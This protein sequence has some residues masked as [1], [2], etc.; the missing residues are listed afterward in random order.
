MY[1]DYLGTG[2]YLFFSLLKPNLCLQMYE[3]KSVS[4]LTPT[5]SLVFTYLYVYLIHL[6]FLYSNEN[7]ENLKRVTWKKPFR[8]RNP[9]H[10]QKNTLIQERA[11]T[12]LGPLLSIVK[13]WGRPCCK[14][15]SF[16][17]KCFLSRQK[18]VIIKYA[19]LILQVIRMK[20]AFSTWL[21]L[22]KGLVITN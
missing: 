15:L 12:Y 11:H 14:V 6:F 18:N 19:N 22:F 4:E 10:H 5:R 7:M 21:V 9:S 8:Y 20:M 3:P 1:S 17:K 2:I 13:H 16:L